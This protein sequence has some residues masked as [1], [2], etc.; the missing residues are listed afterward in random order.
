MIVAAAAVGPNRINEPFVVT[1]CGVPS[2]NVKFVKFNG[3]VAAAPA[4]TLNRR[5]SNV[6][7]PTIG[8]VPKAPTL[9]VPDG[10]LVHLGLDTVQ[11]K[12]EGFTAHVA[13]GD[14]VEAGQPIMT[15]DVP[16]VV[17]SGRNPIVPVVVME[18]QPEDIRLD[19]VIAAGGELTTAQPLIAVAH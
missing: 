16:S 4:N 14:T 12:G 15:Y 7:D 9:K 8:F 1:S 19:D 10:V 5:K 11:L 18:N 3:E 13:K 6:P 2:P 17:A